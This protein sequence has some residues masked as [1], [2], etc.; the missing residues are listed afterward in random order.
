MFDYSSPEPPQDGS[1][2]STVPQQP[3]DPVYSPVTLVEA[4]LD[5][6]R[7][8]I[9]G[10]IFD[11]HNDN[12]LTRLD[13]T[14]HAAA[15]TWIMLPDNQ[16]AGGTIHS[17]SQS[18]ADAINLAGHAIEFS[19]LAMRCDL[20]GVS[21]HDTTGARLYPQAQFDAL[22]DYP[23]FDNKVEL[24]EFHA[25]LSTRDAHEV[26]LL[27]QTNAMSGLS[28]SI[29]ALGVMRDDVT[30]VILALENGGFASFRSNQE[31]FSLSRF[32]YCH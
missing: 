14:N 22:Y 3:S 30:G 18:I 31:I 24:D 25:F 10:I 15:T 23:E 12:N 13:Q 19:S 8:L 29:T 9:A 1:A 32:C 16:G 27:A 20:T 21:Y 17:W 6:F 11:N 7:P 28:Q 5:I 2:T 4:L 26:T